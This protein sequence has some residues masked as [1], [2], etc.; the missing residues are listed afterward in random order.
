MR[1]IV[2]V[3]FLVSALAASATLFY[4]DF[5]DGTAEGWHEISMVEYEVVDGMYWMHGGY[6]ENHGISFNGDATGFMSTPDYSSTCIVLPETG[7]FFGM[8]T[9]FREDAPYNLM[10]VLSEPHQSLRLYRWHWSSIE[11]LDYELFEV[12][13]GEEYRVRFEVSGTDYRG[14][15]WTGGPEDEPDEW[16]VSASD[17]LIAPGSVALF[18]AGLSVDAS[19]SCRF[20]DVDVT[21]IPEEL[22]SDTW[23]ALKR[24]FWIGHN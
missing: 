9:R 8:M 4:D 10:L 24:S 13:L 19:L 6:E 12:S 7:T 21:S 15:A 18:C 11:I 5:D 17:T 23:A 2:P 14:R 22:S 16:M 20:D 1:Q 3:L